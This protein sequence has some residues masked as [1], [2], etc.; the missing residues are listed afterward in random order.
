MHDKST[1]ND[2][3]KRL[4]L[5]FRPNRAGKREDTRYFRIIFILNR[6]IFVLKRRFLL[7]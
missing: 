3:Q 4:I 2:E 1:L 7:V 5:D 6:Q